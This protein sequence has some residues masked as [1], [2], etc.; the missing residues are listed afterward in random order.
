ME[1]T[2]SN[3]GMRSDYSIQQRVIQDK[4]MLELNYMI[5]K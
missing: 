3:K 5:K 4:K 2:K 1:M